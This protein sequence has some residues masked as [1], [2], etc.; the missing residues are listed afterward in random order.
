MSFYR[1]RSLLIFTLPYQWYPIKQSSETIR[2]LGLIFFQRSFS[3]CSHPK[4]YSKALKFLEFMSFEWSNMCH[5]AFETLLATELLLQ[6]P[7]FL[8]PF[9]ITTD[10]SN[11]AIG[12]I[13]SQGRIG[14]DL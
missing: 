11:S 8:Q 7:D 14:S 5:D 4:K 3:C 1:P 13:L 6:R 10:A 9:L 2:D 12:A